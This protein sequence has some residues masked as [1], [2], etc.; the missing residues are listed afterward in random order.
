MH[1]C[2]TMINRYSFVKMYNQSV[3]PYVDSKEWLKS[4][5]TYPEASKWNCLNRNQFWQMDH[6]PSL[7]L[8]HELC[9]ATELNDVV[10]LSLYC[11]IIVSWFWVVIDLLVLILICCD[12]VFLHRL[13]TNWFIYLSECCVAVIVDWTGYCIERIVMNWTISSNCVQYVNCWMLTYFTDL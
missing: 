6:A 5:E 1:S 8:L 9:F 3:R 12:L 13:L 7:W 10:N 2:Q 4:D 11:W